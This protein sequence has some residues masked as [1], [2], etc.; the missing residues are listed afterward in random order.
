MLRERV[1]QE[2]QCADTDRARSIGLNRS[3]F[4]LG[5]LYAVG[6]AVFLMRVLGIPLIPAVMGLVLGPLA[7]QEL[8]RALGISEGDLTVL[9]TRPI[10]GTLLA[11]VVA[12]VAGPWA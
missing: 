11:T 4:D 12:L 10:S 9:V 8:R 2:R 7:E 1:A 5:L 3:A 6:A